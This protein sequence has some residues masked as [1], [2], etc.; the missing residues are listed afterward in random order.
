[1]G[2]GTAAGLFAL[3]L[4]GVL[5]SAERPE[6]AQTGDGIYAARRRAMVTEQLESRDIRDKRV[7]AV[8]GQV[9]RHLFVAPAS[10]EYAYG[11]YPLPIAEGQTISQPYIV[12]LMTQCLELRGGERVL[13]IGTG[14]GYQAA[15]LSLLVSK[16]YTIEYHALLA[17]TA[18]GLLTKLGYSNVEIRSGDGFFGWPENAPFDGI[19]VTCAARRVPE[20]LFEQLKE[21]G[22]LVI[23]VGDTSDVQR[24]VR[25]RKVKGK[26]V[27][28]EITLVRFVPM[29]GADKN[30]K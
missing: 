3:V 26:P 12:A 18:A 6:A 8:M 24:L 30:K 21:G 7:L 10:R 25:V 4:A 29:I 11:D 14:S 13:E 22:L 20:P 5:F 23:P 17:E 19:I 28:E 15:V 27:E 16:V 2:S 1:M 9:P